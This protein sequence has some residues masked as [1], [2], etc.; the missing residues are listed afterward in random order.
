MIF[1]H[2]IW[3]LALAAISIP[4]AIHL[5]NIR[6][7][8]TLK[9]GSIALI[10]AA[11][12]KRSLSRK[13]NDVLLLLLRCLLLVLLAIILAM[14][15][16]SRSNDSSKI[17]GWVLIPEEGVKEA[18]QKFRPKI[19]SLTKAG[20]EFHYFSKGFAKADINKALSDTAH[21]PNSDASYWTLIQQLNGKIAPSL[22]VH[23]FTVN[24]ANH[25]SGE[26]P[27][28]SLNLRW[29]TYA[30]A[31]SVSKW[32]QKAWL[33]N[34]GDI[35][36]VEGNS[37]PAAISYKNYSIRSGDQSTDYTVRSDN[38]RLFVGLKKSN[39]QVPVDTSTWRFSICADK[40]S[41]DA[42]Y[43][44]AALQSIIQFTKHKAAIKQ[45]SDE[46]QIPI[47]QNWLFWLSVKPVSQQLKYNSLFVYENGKPNHSNSWIEAG[48]S[49]KKI[50]LYKSISANDKGVAIWKDG[51]GNPALNLEG[52]AGKNVYHFYSRFDPSWSDLVW[53]NQFPKMLLKLL[54]G[55]ETEPSV[56]YDKRILS[57][58][59]I[60]PVIT[61]EHIASVEKITDQID[62]SRY[63]WLLLALIFFAERWLAHRNK[64]KPIVKNG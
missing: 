10:T 62:L 17:K 32:V 33:T 5:W 1:L 18:Y 36:L 47:Q 19:D 51:F 55:S 9:V 42:G 37:R 30:S 23:V 56:K 6:K 3:F 58:R 60:T 24:E 40:N 25:F 48:A 21:Y 63:I 11:S 45:Y 16:W 22:P 39:E 61:N 53:S 43:L 27:Q 57:D 44:K 7:G 20:F 50:E 8:R 13:L 46:K 14:P 28:V 26:K 35:Q 52:Q 59:Q 41:P 34:N 31:D 64:S 2:P 49:D 29:Q 4:V 54:V 12:Q 38:G 15:L